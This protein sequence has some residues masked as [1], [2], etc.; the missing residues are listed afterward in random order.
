MPAKNAYTVG[1]KSKRQEQYTIRNIPGSLDKA[2]R[3]QSK[4]TGKSLNDV[5]LQT[6][7][8]G[9]GLDMESVAYNDLD[10]LIGTWEEDATVN[11]ALHA[12]RQ[13]DTTL[14]S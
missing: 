10:F 8:R 2:L 4:E 12:Q 13:I 6:L 11:D 3:R 9:T 1:M 5:L 7:R 14:W